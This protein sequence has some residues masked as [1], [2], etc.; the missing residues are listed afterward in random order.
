MSVMLWM[1]S[2]LPV[3]VWAGLIFYLSHIP[4]L[5]TG[6]GLWDFLLRKMAHMVE[7]AVLCGLLIR[8]FVRT[9]PALGLKRL[10]VWCFLLSLLYAIS[11][12]IHQSFVP[13]RGPSAMDVLVDS[14]GI[15]MCI[16]S[17]R[18]KNTL[19]QKIRT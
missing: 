18:I 9:W 17:Y 19:W 14:V 8:A 7:Y 5:D 10:L 12:E 11:D 13:G 1:V 4:S 6:W 3:G 15:V 16:W 2:W